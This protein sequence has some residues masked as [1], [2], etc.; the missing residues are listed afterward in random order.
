MGDIQLSELRK[1]ISVISTKLIYNIDEQSEILELI[2]RFEDYQQSLVQ[3]ILS[4]QNDKAMIS[5]K[6]II[7]NIQKSFELKD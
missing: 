6:N 4:K 5:L 7:A 2:Q 3:V 1:S